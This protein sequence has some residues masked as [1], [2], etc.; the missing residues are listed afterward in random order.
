M[1]RERK[2]VDEYVIE[3][4]AGYGCRWEEIDCRTTSEECRQILA[5]YRKNDPTGRYRW[6]HKRV[7]KEVA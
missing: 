5:D 2:T 3:Q 6:R 7:P 4:N 1:P